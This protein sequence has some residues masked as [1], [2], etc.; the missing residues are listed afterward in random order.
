M[1]FVS[2]KIGILLLFS[3]VG[4]QGVVGVVRAKDAGGAGT[5][6]LIDDFLAAHCFDCHD[7]DVQK[8]DL[9]LTSLA[10]DFSKPADHFAWGMVLDR[11]A[12]G[13]MPPKKKP[14]PEAEELKAV[15]EILFEQLAAVER[16]RNAEEGRA[17][18]R[19]LNRKEYE[20]TLRD[21]LAL[22]HLRIA[23]ALP[24]EGNAF[25]YDK[26]AA[27]LDFSHVH[28]SRLM[29]VADIGLRRAIVP[30]RERPESQTIRFEVRDPK[31]FERNFNGFNAL[32]K[33]TK[34]IPLNGMEVDT[35]M[36]YFQGDF[37][38]RIA[39]HAKDLPPYFDGFAIFING[40]FN[41]GMTIRPLKPT[42]AGYYK[43]RV[44]GFGVLNDHGE[45]VP[46]DRM[47][48]VGLYSNDR[49]LGFVDLPPYEPSTGEIT[50]WL[51]P[52]DVIKP[53][54]ASAPFPRVK[55]LT[56]GKPGEEYVGEPVYERFRAHGVAFRWFELEGPLYESWPPESHVRLLGERFPGDELGGEGEADLIRDARSL[57]WGFLGRALRRPVTPEDM[58]VPMRT[59]VQKLKRD[60]P[61]EEAMISGYRAVL[62]SP[63]FLLMR[64]DPGRLDGYALAERLSYFLWNSPPDGELIRLAKTER[65]LRKDVLRGQVDRLL[66]DPR[67]ERFVEHFLDKWLKLEDIALTEPDANLYPEYTP[68]LMDSALWEAR[69][70]FSEMLARDLGARYVVDSDFLMINQRLA[71]LYGIPGVLGNE[72]RRVS[73]KGDSVR[74]GFLTQAALLK[75]TANGTVTS[76]VVRG[77]F[78]LTHLL[79]D[80]PPP[81]PPSVPAVEPD[82]SGVTTIR[83]QLV[84]H[85]ED[86]ACAGCHAKIDPPG[87]ALES[88]DVMGGYRERYRSLEKGKLL[89]LVLEAR[90]AE[91]RAGLEVDGSGE[92]EDG[93]KFRGIREFRKLLVEREDELARNLLEQLIIYGTGEPVGFAD[94]EIVDEML[95]SAAGDGYGVRTL[96]HLVV[97]SPLFLKK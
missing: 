44:N 11:V 90:P 38:R 66:D 22:P 97:R 3:C 5:F 26:S 35:S 7:A 89:G 73:L 43:I 9:D 6:E 8:G 10:H 56:R 23:E 96:L 15:T 33:Q 57:M 68:L 40:A 12:S 13:E 54:V 71:D 28:A 2:F 87:F 64:M 36:R 27:A 50:V 47:E 42:V 63:D 19:R 61:F 83:E 69:A 49:T 94:R 85:R 81:P 60:E 59:V 34:G 55:G 24:P 48:T 70:Y 4:A 79:G 74:G 88:F 86:E 17:T 20:E 51:E 52:N 16:E 58:K 1:K 32:L 46:S 72:I 95:E 37:E 29:E 93:S 31:N 45:F 82:I 75:T 41:L 39:G 62:T 77:D 18:V 80:P 53:L 30:A 76:P 84:R 14:R 67:S 21:V 91:T 92:F 65:L 25:G 78:V